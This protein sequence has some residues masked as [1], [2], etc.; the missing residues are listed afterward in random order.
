[1]YFFSAILYRFLINMLLLIHNLR[2]ILWLESKLVRFQYKINAT[3]VE[4]SY[5]SITVFD[6]FL[7]GTWLEN[8][9][10]SHHFSDIIFISGLGLD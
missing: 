5:V 3:L 2:F 7:Y 9:Q 6:Q 8:M 4:N 10:L 1:M